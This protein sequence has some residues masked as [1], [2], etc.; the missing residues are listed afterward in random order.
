[1]SVRHIIGTSGETGTAVLFSKAPFFGPSSWILQ[2]PYVAT[3]QNKCRNIIK[4][5]KR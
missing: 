3:I 2:Y 5:I 1:M 4:T